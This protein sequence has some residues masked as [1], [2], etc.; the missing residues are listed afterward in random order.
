MQLFALIA[1]AT[2]I[3]FVFG[4]DELH[5]ALYFRWLRRLLRCLQDNDLDGEPSMHMLWRAGKRA[6]LQAI[7][8][9][10]CGLVAQQASNTQYLLA[11]WL[12][13]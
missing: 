4:G 1:A 13:L 8:Q 2:S 10:V 11:Y 12:N 7:P 3:C 9:L 5:A 6:Y